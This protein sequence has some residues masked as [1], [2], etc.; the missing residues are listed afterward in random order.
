MVFS[1]SDN[2]NTETL[3]KLLIFTCMS[4]KS[5]WQFFCT[6]ANAVSYWAM[7]KVHVLNDKSE[8]RF[9]V[10]HYFSVRDLIADGDKSC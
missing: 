2:K 5:S 10:T 7:Y 9:Q 4:Q 1:I 3:T 8:F 6:D